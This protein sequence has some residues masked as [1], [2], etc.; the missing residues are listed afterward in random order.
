MRAGKGQGSRMATFVAV[1]GFVLHA[2]AP[3]FATTSLEGRIVTFRVIAYDDPDAPLFDGIGETV[4]VGTGVEFG[5]YPEGAQNGLDVIPAQVNIGPDRVEV[6]WPFAGT[7]TVM[8]AEFNGYELKFEADCVLIEGAGI[9]HARTTMDL[10]DDAVT[11]SRDTLWIDLAGQP[12]GPDE[13]VAVV[14]DVGDCP[15]S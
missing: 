13:R 15:L 5:L 3:A 8:Q 14:I 7:G 6:T 1:S 11:F 9:D 12:F 4:K 10:P 2:T